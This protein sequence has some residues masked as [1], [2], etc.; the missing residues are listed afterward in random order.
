M[1]WFVFYYCIVCVVL[2]IL[3]LY[4][5]SLGLYVYEVLCT[6]VVQK[7]DEGAVGVEKGGQN[8]KR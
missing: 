4:F 5:F 3:N 6:T 1:S 7:A 2:C 8:V